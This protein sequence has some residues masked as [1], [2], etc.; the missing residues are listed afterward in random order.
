[1]Y[2]GGRIYAITAIGKG[3]LIKGE[4]MMKR[5]NNAAKH[6]GL[7]FAGISALLFLSTFLTV[8]SCAQT[9]VYADNDKTIS[10]LC[11][12][13]INNPERGSSDNA[14]PWRGN[15]VYYGTYGEGS[16]KYRVLSR[17][18]SDF[19]G[20]TMLLDC[21]NT[22]I[23]MEFDPSHPASPSWYSSVLKTW[24]KGNGFYNGNVF[25]EQEKNAI[26]ASNKSS[27]AGDGKARF[28]F[29]PLTGE[30][31]FILDAKEALN[32]DYGYEEN[33]DNNNKKRIKLNMDG[34]IN[35]WWL[36]SSTS[37]PDSVGVVTTNGKVQFCDAINTSGVSPAF[38]L[39]LE[40][41]IFSSVISGNPGDIGAEYK[42]TV[43]DAGLGIIP[44]T[45]TRNGTTITVPYTITGANAARANQVSVLITD[46]EYSAGTAS[47]SGYTYLKLSGGVSG[48]GTFTLPAEYADE[49]CGADYYAYILAEDVNAGTA[50]DY[51]S[52]PASI[53]IPAAPAEQVATCTITFEPNG[54]K[55]D[56]DDQTVDKGVRTQLNKNKFTRSGYSFDGWNTDPDGDGTGY[57][58][59]DYISVQKDITLYAQWERDDHEDDDEDEDDHTPASWILNPNEKQQL[60]II[61]TGTPEG[62]CAGYQEQGA[63]AKAVFA[64][65]TPRGWSEAFEFN[66]LNKYRQPEMTLKKGT[67]TLTIPSE[68]RKAGRQFALIALTK[69]GQTFLLPDTDTNPNTVTATINVEGYAF[70]L[71]YKD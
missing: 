24:L 25:T 67:L 51:A 8:I 60:S 35:S 3:N 21:D 10:G 28:Y 38:N 6:K 16:V 5:S 39:S 61:F 11:T 36:R 58:D 19:G 68:Y 20:K 42:L 59:K 47:D 56:M 14:Y 30:K 65:A 66:L 33:E 9:I 70:S 54:G 23:D 53:T 1:M 62:T 63:A 29:Q 18:T 64:A 48:S 13:A 57:E 49:T 44:G 34:A 4:K 46:S 52:V 43:A 15:Y 41:V 37:E 45:I 32:P 69:G 50:T 2:S 71:I 31:V 12:G 26:T 40:S 27:D 55:G 17:S 7:L 22:L